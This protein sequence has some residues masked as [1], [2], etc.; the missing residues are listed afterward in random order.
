MNGDD[1]AHSGVYY[2]EA[3]GH[4]Q[5]PDPLN[6]C[7]YATVALLTWLL[8]PVALAGFAGLA[9]AGYWRARRRGLRRSRCWLR[10]TRLVLCYLAVLAGIG[11]GAVLW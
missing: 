4:R 9:F 8:G 7:I 11:V 10:D 1:A 3:I 2:A 6:L 5:P